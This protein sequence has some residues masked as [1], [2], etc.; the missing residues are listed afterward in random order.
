MRLDKMTPEQ[1]AR[2]EA[3]CAR[4][5]TRTKVAGPAEACMFCEKSIANPFDPA[6]AQLAGA[7]VIPF[8]G[9]FCSQG[10]ADA[11]ER[12]YGIQFKRDATGKVS[13]Q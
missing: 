6:K 5:N 3:H 4:R 13:Y 1:R 12:D 7:V 8:F 2:Y 9:F 11:F 10:C